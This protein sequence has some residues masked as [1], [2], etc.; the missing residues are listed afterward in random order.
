MQL[1]EF[2]GSAQARQR[3]WA[4]S[5]V[6]W[7]RFNLARPNAGHEAVAR[8]QQAGIVG[9]VI[10]QNVDGLHQAAGASDVT[11]LHG[12]LAK[13]VCLT[14]GDRTSRWDLDA[15]MR[16]ANPAYTVTSDE[17]RPDGDIALNDLDVAAFVVPICLVC[18]RDTLK[19]EVVFFGESVPKPLVEHCFRLTESA[20]SL[21]VLGSSL[22]VMSGYRFV[23]RA[24]ARGIPV[25]IITRGPTRGDGEATLQL[26]AE[27]GPTLTELVSRLGA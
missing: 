22:K 14:C 20:G 8:L 6:G 13:V 21:L 17:I 11:E 16:E 24:A 5:Y 27:L 26:D 25:V 1:S 23:R 7:Q 9:P 12:S 2:T 15:R 4:R 19:P 3:Y 10:T 18:G